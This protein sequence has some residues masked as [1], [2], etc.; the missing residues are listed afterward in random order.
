[1][2]IG[3]IGNIPSLNNNMSFQNENSMDNINYASAASGNTVGTLK[4][5]QTTVHTFAINRTNNAFQPQTQKMVCCFCL[6]VFVFFCL[7][8][9]IFF[10]V[11]FFVLLL[12]YFFCDLFFLF[13]Q[14]R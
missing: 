13:C 11:T 8:F 3:T 14:K 9:F 2:I 12:S 4:V 6:F 1:M 5:P 7:G 10:Y